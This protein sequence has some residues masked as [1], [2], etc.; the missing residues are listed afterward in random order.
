M[1]T[2][3][4]ALIAASGAIGTVILG[5]LKA[6]DDRTTRE[7]VAQ[8]SDV[9]FW[10]GEWS[11]E[12]ER[13]DKWQAEYYALLTTAKHGAEQYERVVTTIVAPKESRP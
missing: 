10:R 5:V 6:R 9:T 13:A 2:V 1:T 4:L 7:A 3:V 11:K 12:R 8:Q